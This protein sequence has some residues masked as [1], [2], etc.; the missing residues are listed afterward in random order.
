MSMNWKFL[1]NWRVILLAILV[2][3]SLITLIPTGKSGVVVQSVSASSPLAGKIHSGDIMSWANEKDIKSVDDFTQYETFTGTFRFIVNGNLELVQINTPGLGVSVT[4]IPSSK[5]NLGLDLIGGTRVLLTPTENASLD[6]IQQAMATLQTRINIFGLKEAKFQEVKDLSGN[7]H[8]QIE[9]AGSGRTDVENLLSKQGKF[10]AKIPLNLKFPSATREFFNS[11]LRFSNGTLELNGKNI[12]VNGTF[13][14][15]GIEFEYLNYTPSSAGLIATVVT[16]AD[17][18][19]VCL[20]E[21]PGICTSVVQRSQNGYEFAFQITI[22]DEAAQKFAAVTKGMQVTTQPGTGSSYLESPIIFYIDNNP[23]TSLSISS[24]L[25][26]RPIT[27]PVINGFRTDREDALE[28]KLYLQ[29]I[30]QS[31]A[32]PVSFEITRVDQISATLGAAF[33]SSALLAGFGAI[34]AVSVVVFIRYR[35]WKISVPVIIASVSDVLIILGI[36]VLINWT[37]DLPAIVGIIATV[38]TSVDAQIMIIDELL[39]KGA[40][41]VYTFKQRLQRA[42]FIIFGSA[43]TVIAAMLPL[44]FIGIGAMRG[45][46]I[47]TTIGVLVSVLVT[48]PAFGK[49]VE[50]VLEGSGEQEKK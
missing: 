3:A 36:A 7:Y 24:D 15:N 39:F 37:I 47:I 34:I 1:R 2:I 12:P 45:F 10:E 33:T 4:N 20:T 42:F 32:L 26:G 5:L 48:R 23:I 28:E 6:Q 8:I 27:N 11:T 50:A 29:S 46:A 21:Q 38:G 40:E 44:M 35:N 16:G 19:S 17:V 25:A 43:A 30:V 18:K 31:G 9:M 22:G 14:A 49:I 41:K 13:I